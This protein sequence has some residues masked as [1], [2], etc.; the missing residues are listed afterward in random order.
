M[1][2]RDRPDAAQ[3]VLRIVLVLLISLFL[4]HWIV[5]ARYAVD[6]P[7]MD[8][9]I[10]YDWGDAGSFKVSRLFAAGNDTLMPVG[11][12]LDAVNVR[13]FAGDNVISQILSFGAVVGSLLLLQYALLKRFAPSTIALA[14]AALS[15]VLLLQPETYW[16]AQT[17]A[18]YQALPLVALLCG[19]WIAVTSP[20]SLGT[21]T[22]L[23]G[24]VAALGGLSYVSGAF[25]ALTAAVV[26]GFFWWRRGSGPLQA[27]RAATLGFGLGALLSLPAQLWVLL[28]VQHGHTHRADA[29]WTSPFAPQ[30][31][32]FIVGIVGR[33]IGFSRTESGWA[34]AVSLL[35]ML[36]L[37][38]LLLVLLWGAANRS[39]PHDDEDDAFAFIYSALGAT[40]L[41]YLCMV[42]AGRANLGAPTGQT[43]LGSF[44]LGQGRFYFFWVSLLIPWVLLAIMRLMR[45][46]SPIMQN[47]TALVLGL[48]LL[49]MF[50][51]NSAAI[52]GLAPY[53]RFTAQ[54][55]QEGLQC[56]RSKIPEGP[57]YLCP[58]LFPADLSRAL[59]Y[60]ALV[61]A[62]FTVYLPAFQA[63]QA[64][65]ALWQYETVWRMDK[66]TI[67]RLGTINGSF[68]QVEGGLQIAAKDDS[69]V[70]V[71]IAQAAPALQNCRRLKF[72]V[73]VNRGKASSDPVQ[74]YYIP[75]GAPDFVEANSL[76]QYPAWTAEGE[77]SIDFQ[78]GSLSGF[79]PRLRFDP[80]RQAG[81]YLVRAIEVAC[82]HPRAQ[83]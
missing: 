66:S 18:F 21:K 80:A 77:A 26:A 59:D 19:L 61:G 81:V 11:R 65:A 53:Y 64:N 63:D 3:L 78:V 24:V 36:A 31:W 82:G 22:A 43:A 50:L 17:V 1:V 29:P 13:L 48:L 15:L 74:L 9:W 57:P 39:V 5:L 62:K 69:Q 67:D 42:A 33:A 71:D 60:A 75:V 16:G 79:V 23:I 6:L 30:F 73:E 58:S 20:A 44:A 40:V 52:F 25:A 76:V 12:F 38:A 83:S 4:V 7:Y 72:H 54:L 27:Y 8:D 37:V 45:G 41:F 32:E 28:V 46:S 55:K 51:V 2:I 34:F 70:I 10:G 14:L 49:A 35:V 56:L 47:A 68:E